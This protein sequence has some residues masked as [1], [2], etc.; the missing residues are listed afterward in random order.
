MV[1]CLEAGSAFPPY[2]LY[3]CLSQTMGCGPATCSGI[4][5]GHQEFIADKSGNIRAY[6]RIGLP[7]E[8]NA[9]LASVDRSYW[10]DYYRHWTSTDQGK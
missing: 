9:T 10:T 3:T 4:I 8:I 5:Q 7:P 1:R 6:G 2:N